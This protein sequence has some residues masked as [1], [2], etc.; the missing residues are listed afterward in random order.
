MYDLILERYVK[1]NIHILKKITNEVL[2]CQ[3][4]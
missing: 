3:C 4:L 1:I 2:G